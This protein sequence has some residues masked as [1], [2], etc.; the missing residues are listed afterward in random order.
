MIEWA[1]KYL[2][3]GW[4]VIP[5]WWITQDGV[6]ACAKSNK[7][8]APGKHPIYSWTAFQ[9]RL[10]TYDEVDKWWKTYPQANI[11]IIT[12]SISGLSVI[13]TDRDDIDLESKTLV[14]KTGGGGRHYYYANDLI[15]PNAVG[16]LNRID[17]RSEG[18]YVIAP[19]S[20]HKS[21]NVYGWIQR[22]VPEKLPNSLCLLIDKKPGPKLIEEGERN[23]GLASLSGTFIRLG[24]SET[25]ATYIT[26]IINSANCNPPLPYNEVE[27]IV[28]SI[29]SGH[30][31]RYGTNGATEESAFRVITT[32]DMVQRY[33]GREDDWLIDGWLPNRSEERRVGKECRL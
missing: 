24:A 29:Y 6:C 15:I 7:C 14:S 18:G 30:V 20:N 28:K 12:G 1:Q 9:H 8:D 11:A 13:D 23:S 16:I 33:G 26:S 5:T 3:L 31:K 21:G 32:R 10:P 2:S 19:P 27:V 25:E 4:S 22:T 17:I